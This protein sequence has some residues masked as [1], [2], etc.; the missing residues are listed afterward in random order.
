[1]LRTL[2]VLVALVV[3]PA[4]QAQAA[5]EA[6]VTPVQGRFEEVRDAVVFAIEGKGLV[7][8]YT[9]HIGSMLERTGKDI[10]AARRIYDQAESFE[11]C[12][13]RVSRQMME[14]DPANIV[15]CPFVVSVYTLPGKPGTVF[16]AYRKPMAGPKAVEALLRELVAEAAGK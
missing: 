3:L 7:I 2:S 4:V 13:A 12:S 15:N 5:S 6:V 8:N 1:M 10:G 9:G 11:F 16:L 14:A